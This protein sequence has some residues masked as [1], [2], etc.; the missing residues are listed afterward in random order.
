MAVL[1][2]NNSGSGWT[3]PGKY[4]GGSLAWGESTT[5]EGDTIA[6]VQAAFGGRSTAGKLEFRAAPDGQTG[7]LRQLNSVFVSTEQ[8][9]TGALQNIPHGLG[10]VP[11][12]VVITPTDLSPATI[13]QYT[14]VEG[15]HD[16]ANIKVTVTTGKK[17][18][19]HAEP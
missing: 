6:N 16:A 9:G 2:K 4:G 17:Y 12:N 14:V 7:N 11:S 15:A 18:K 5:I 10:V 19:I 3:I 13:G 1:V 8:T